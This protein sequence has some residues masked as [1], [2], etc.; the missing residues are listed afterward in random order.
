MEVYICPVVY[1][2]WEIGALQWAHQIRTGSTVQSRFR[3]LSLFDA[4]GRGVVL[5]RLAA[6]LAH[7]ADDAPAWAASGVRR[8]QWHARR[9]RFGAQEFGHVM[10]TGLVELHD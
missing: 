4:V 7:G 10:P 6:G 5:Q 9:K 3:I 1:C 8:P 2:A